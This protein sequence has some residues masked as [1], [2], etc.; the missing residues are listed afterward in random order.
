M[1]DHSLFYDNLVE[2]LEHQQNRT[3]RTNVN[4]EILQEFFKSTPRP[5]QSRTPAQTPVP[6][7]TRTP[8]Q[9]HYQKR[10]PSVRPETPA[11]SV[12]NPIPPPDFSHHKPPVSCAV[13]ELTL[14]ELRIMTLNCRNCELSAK[15]QN[16]VFGEGKPNAEVLFIGESPGRDEDAQG[17]PFVGSAGQ[18]LNRMI[19]AMQLRRET[20]YLANIVKCRPPGNRVPFPSEAKSCLPYLHRQIELIKPKVIVLLGGIPLL[21]ILNLTGIAN[22][23]GQ[24]GEYNGIPVMPTFHPSFLLRH[25][26]LPDERTLKGQ[27]WSDLQEVMKLLGKP[28]PKK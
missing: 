8:V 6:T 11:E 7:Q 26:G 14:D 15:R 1:N 24:W 20:V 12:L 5:A 27:V 22:R 19:G 23:R 9:G 28:L 25:K 18:L 21:H 4:S 13:G 2:C 17:R 10:A 3:P 16:V